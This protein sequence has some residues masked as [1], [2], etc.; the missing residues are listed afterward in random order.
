MQLG[1]RIRVGQTLASTDGSGRFVVLKVGTAREVPCLDGQPLVVAVPAPCS[2]S[3]QPRRSRGGLEPGEHYADEPTGLEIMC[4][5]PGAGALVYAGR[6]MTMV[7]QR[8]LRFPL[9]QS[10]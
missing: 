3:A 1:T 10:A 9:W 8:Q 6:P 4:T 7:P 2:A 5:A